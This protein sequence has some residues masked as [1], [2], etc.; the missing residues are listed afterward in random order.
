MKLK[1]RLNWLLALI[2]VAIFLEFTHGAAVAIFAVSALAILPLAGLIGHA[3]ED[4]AA[5]S[6]PQVGGLLNATFGNVT[7]MIIAFFLILQGEIEVV[8]ASIT[9]SIIGNVLVVL[10]LSFLLGGWKREQQ[11]FNRASAGLHSSSLVIAVVALLM[12]ALFHLS[13]EANNFREEAVSIGVAAILMTVYLL[14]LFFSFKTHRNLFRSTFDH[15]EPKWSVGKGVGMLAGATILVALMSEFLVGAL[16]ETVEE[17]GLSKLFV[18][19][20]IV[21]IVGNAAEHS[22]AILLAMKDKMDVSIEIAIGSS[23][24]IALFIAPLLV[25]V[26]LA[27][28]HPMDFIFSGIEIAAVGFSSAIL[29]F[30]AL[31]G[32]STWFEGA[33]LVAAYL[34][35]AVSFFFL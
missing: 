5:R 11:Q 34:I 31:D 9:G 28:G 20:I 21:P 19:L 14:S 18:G 25:F 2:P 15:G 13:P 10:G 29:G 1:P 16:E 23:T 33:Q 30:I 27:V 4:L 7:E 22:S 26:S 8:K 12:P 6:G 17:V 35:M 3:T 32:R 24:Q